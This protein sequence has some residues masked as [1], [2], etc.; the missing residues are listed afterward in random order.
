MVALEDVLVSVMKRMHQLSLDWKLRSVVVPP[1]D[2]VIGS[3][4]L[5]EG[6]CATLVVDFSCVV[7]L[8]RHACYA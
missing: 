4:V 6:V 7:E 8:V 5:C 1:L 2:V 3:L